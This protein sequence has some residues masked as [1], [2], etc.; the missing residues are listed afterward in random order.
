[1]CVNEWAD[2]GGEASPPV[3]LFD[4]VFALPVQTPTTTAELTYAGTGCF[5]DGDTGDASVVRFA[6]PVLALF[7]KIHIPKHLRLEKDRGREGFL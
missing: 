1:M 4:D 2:V 5:G 7:V 3:F 6:G